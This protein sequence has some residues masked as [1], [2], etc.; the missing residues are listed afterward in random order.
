M[1]GEIVDPTSTY[2]AEIT[3]ANGVEIRVSVEV[4]ERLGIRDEPELGEH[5]QIASN[6]LRGAVVQLVKLSNENEPPF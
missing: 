1:S 4:P 3:M 5:V 2:A 6:R